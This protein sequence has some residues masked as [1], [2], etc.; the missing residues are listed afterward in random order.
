MHVLRLVCRERSIQRVSVWIV[1]PEEDAHTFEAELRR[2]VPCGHIMYGRNLRAVAGRLD[3][4]DVFFQEEGDA[5]MLVVHLTWSVETDPKWPGV[6]EYRTLADSLE[7]W[8]REA[9]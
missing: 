4:D 9:F 8:P 5:A 6:T 1:I 2:E 3:Q 7:W